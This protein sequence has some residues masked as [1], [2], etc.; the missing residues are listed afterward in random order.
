M[1]PRR[2]QVERRQETRKQLLLAARE[3]FGRRGFA[4]A[5]L[6]EISEAAGL[7]RGALYYNFPKGKEQ[8]FLALLDERIAERAGTVQH[9]FASNGGGADQV[10]RLA[11]EASY[12]ASAWMVSPENREWRL[13]FFEFALHAARDQQF[14]AEFARSEQGMRRALVQ[15]IES[16]AADLGGQPPIE[17]STLAL[18]INALAN[19]LALDALVDPDAV[20]EDLFPTLIGFLVRGMVAAAEAPQPTTKASGR[21]A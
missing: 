9:T 21:P 1:P 13:L 12:D 10:V 5:S 4:G 19:G 17:P 7:S 2:T 11:Q 14:A 3:V 6:D 8:L 18:G 15:V 20:P 16:V